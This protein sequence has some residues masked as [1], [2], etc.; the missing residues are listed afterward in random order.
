MFEDNDDLNSS[1]YNTPQFARQVMSYKNWQKIAKETQCR[2]IS[3][4]ETYELS[5]RHLGGGM[6]EVRANL[7]YWKGGRPQRA[8]P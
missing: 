3:C 4:G 6:Y 1:F 7:T 8:K 5:A 2:I